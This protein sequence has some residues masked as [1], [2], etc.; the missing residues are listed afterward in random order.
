MWQPGDGNCYKKVDQRACAYAGTPCFALPNLKY[1]FLKRIVGASY[2]S[3]NMCARQ[4]F[5]IT[6]LGE[7]RHN[8]YVTHPK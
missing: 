6:Q 4:Q 1:K 5:K 7:L 2:T 8:E 3:V